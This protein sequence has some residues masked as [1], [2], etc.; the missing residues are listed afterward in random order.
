MTERTSRVLVVGLAALWLLDGLLQ[1]Q[2]SMFSPDMVPSMWAPV[3]A[4]NPAWLAHLVQWSIGIAKPWILVFNALIAATQLLIGLLLLSPR[5]AIQRAGLW[6]SVL[7]GL[8]VWVFGEAMGGLFAGG[9]NLA[10]GAPGSAV[11]YSVGAAALLIPADAWRRLTGFRHTHPLQAIAAVILLAGAAW[12]CAPADWTALGL[13]APPASSFMMPQ[14]GLLRAALSL[15][16]GLAVRA[17][18][19]INGLLVLAMVAAAIGVLAAIDRTAVMAAVLA[20]IAVVWLCGQDLGMLFSGGATDPNTMPLLALFVYAAWAGHRPEHL[21]DDAAT[22]GH[23]Q[24][25]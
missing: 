20:L 19:L 7:F 4:G 11:L 22:H 5:P 15:A 9:A 17:P 3:A 12:Q 6:A 10:A 21:A 13:S 8:A 16:S 2:P 14:P 23:H 24:A 1:L 25:A 18:V